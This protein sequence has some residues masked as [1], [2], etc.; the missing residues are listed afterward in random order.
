[1]YIYLSLISI[2]A[3]P[4]SPVAGSV[5]LSIVVSDDAP[6]IELQFPLFPSVAE[7]FAAFFRATPFAGDHM[8]KFSAGK[9]TLY[10]RLANGLHVGLQADSSDLPADQLAW[11]GSVFFARMG[12]P[13]PKSSPDDPPVRAVEAA[14]VDQ[15]DGRLSTLSLREP[16]LSPVARV[17]GRPH[18]GGLL[19]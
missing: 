13:S 3:A 17:L 18:L 8:E 4:E 12:P 11:E 9:H 14:E 6:G 1:M 5:K 15:I 7:I 2:S 19:L 16:D 10:F